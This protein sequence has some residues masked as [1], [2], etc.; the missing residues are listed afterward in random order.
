M[1]ELY[2]CALC[3]NE[4]DLN[5]SNSRYFIFFCPI[6]KNVDILM[7]YKRRHPRKVCDITATLKYK[8]NNDRE[9]QTNVV[10]KNISLHGYKLYFL[11]YKVLT[12]IS[13]SHV[14][15]LTYTLPNQNQDVITDDIKL[16]YFLQ[17]DFCCGVAVADPVDYSF[18]IRKKGF[19]LMDLPN[20]LEIE[21]K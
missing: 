13:R 16:I 6:C 2:K 12:Y 17:N 20:E 8:D 5:S 9:R 15:Q 14:C 10:I 11:D 4:F 1:Y 7:D 3:N 19:W 18:N 21:K